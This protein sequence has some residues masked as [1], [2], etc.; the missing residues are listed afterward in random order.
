MTSPRHPI[1]TKCHQWEKRR[2]LLVGMWHN[3]WM[4]L[5]FL[6]CKIV[7]AMT[8]AVTCLMRMSEYL[9]RSPGDGEHWLRSHDV[10]FGMKDGSVVPVWPISAYQLSAIRSVVITL[11]SAKNDK[12][13]EGHRMEFSIIEVDATHAFDLAADKCSWAVRAQQLLRP[14]RPTIHGCS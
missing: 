7:T 14:E 11:R 1:Y 2:G 12:E 5:L 8:L 10:A 4:Q 6:K 13:D 9:P 3:R